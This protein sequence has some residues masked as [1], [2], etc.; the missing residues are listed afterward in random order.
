MKLELYKWETIAYVGKNY[1]YH[2]PNIGIHNDIRRPLPTPTPRVIYSTNMQYDDGT[3]FDPSPYGAGSYVVCAT[4][5]IGQNG[6]VLVTGLK[7][8]A[9]PIAWP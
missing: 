8:C 3:V 4:P 7:V 6:S 9:G 5:I 1:K 2:I